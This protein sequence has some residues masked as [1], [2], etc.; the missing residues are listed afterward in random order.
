[1]IDRNQVS[2][3]MMVRGADGK[4]LGRV[5]ACREGSFI[6]E[7]GFFF[8]TDYVA[9]YD[10]VRGV[11][12]DEVQL[13]RP[14]EEL[15]HAQRAVAR[16]GGMGESITLGLGSG[17]VDTTQPWAR[18]EEE[19]EQGRRGG[20]RGDEGEP[21]TKYD[22]GGHSGAAPTSYDDEGGSGGR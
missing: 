2:E 12:D 15:A 8:A 11:S 1:M 13:S 7:K 20:V 9:R 10:D 6:I 16:E 17:L 3:G 4:K 5:L 14:E 19:E 18:A 21:G 22:M